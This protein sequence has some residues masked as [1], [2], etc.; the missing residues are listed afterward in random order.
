MAASLGQ[1]GKLSTLCL[2]KLSHKGTKSNDEQNISPPKMAFCPKCP[3]MYPIKERADIH[4][5][6]HSAILVMGSDFISMIFPALMVLYD[7]MIQCVCADISL[8][9]FSSSFR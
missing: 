1:I 4:S 8:L 3:Y 7:S 9:L 5:E 6:C 2:E